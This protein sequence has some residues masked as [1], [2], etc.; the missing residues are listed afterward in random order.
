MDITP[1]AYGVR[2]HTH[3]RTLA[4][5]HTHACACAWAPSSSTGCALRPTCSGAL[6]A[7]TPLT[8]GS[9]SSAACRGRGATR[10]HT[11]VR[12][13]LVRAQQSS[14]EYAN[15]HNLV[16]RVKC[17]S[18]HGLSGPLDPIK[19]LRLLMQS[20]SMTELI[21]TV[22]G[23]YSRKLDPAGAATQARGAGCGDGPRRGARRG[24]RSA[25]LA[26][27][28]RRARSRRPSRTRAGTAA[29]APRPP[30]PRPAWVGP[31]QR[32]QKS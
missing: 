8:H 32:A 3:M 14:R 9:A 28:A 21:H 10:T 29:G 25:C 24:R 5:V 6:G 1:Y 4:C 23:D 11:D 15:T 17:A 22:Q 12:M 20:W 31:P 13:W 18:A 19:P 26:A 2:A 7:S 27:A 30:R 16:F